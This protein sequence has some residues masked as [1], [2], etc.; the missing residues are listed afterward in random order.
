MYNE[1]L[2]NRFLND[3]FLASDTTDADVAS[4]RSHFN[5]IAPFEEKLGKD[6]CRMTA[7]E[8]EESLNGMRNIR[9]SSVAVKVSWLKRYLRWCRDHNIEGAILDP[10]CVVIDSTYSIRNTMV[11]SPVHLQ[12]ILDKVF[13]PVELETVDNLHRSFFWMAF[14]GIPTAF[15]PHIRNKDIDFASLSVRYD[16]N[17]EGVLYREGIKTI[18]STAELT[19]FR[20]LHPLYTDK[21]P[22]YK[23]RVANDY[24]FRGIYRKDAPDVK[25]FSFL[26]AQAHAAIVRY[27]ET[28]KDV[29]KITYKTVL[30][31][32]MFYRLYELERA[33]V[34]PDFSGMVLA[35]IIDKGR[36][37]TTRKQLLHVARLH[38]IDYNNWK[39]AF[40][41]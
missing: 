30:T 33:G 8:A 18:R 38:R 26:A 37:P 7:S 17:K 20:Y 24:L 9:Q 3:T 21:N 22:T 11:S 29:V 31:S 34:E 41:I 36:Q 39:D 16:T 5:S 14:A 40:R 25:P 19:G 13:K 32:G 2:K 1:E 35:D 4:V 10:E 28:A 23:A 27:N 12:T 15:V 6:F